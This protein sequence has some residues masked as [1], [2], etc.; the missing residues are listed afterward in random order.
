MKALFVISLDLPS[1][2]S[3]VQV[4]EHLDPP[5]I[6]HFAGEVRVVVGADVDET[7]KF[8]DEG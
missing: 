3:V 7:I 8:L 1:P 6:P 4:M 5:E 2:D